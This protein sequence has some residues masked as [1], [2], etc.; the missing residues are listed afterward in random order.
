ML[1]VVGRDEITALMEA[2]RDGSAP[3]AGADDGTHRAQRLCRRAI[4]SDGSP[5]QC[6]SDEAE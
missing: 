5:A 3:I 2:L 6:N 4:R 1:G